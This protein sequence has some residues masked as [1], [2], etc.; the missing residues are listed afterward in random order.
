MKVFNYSELHFSEGTSF[1]IHNL[2]RPVL[3][4]LY[5][6]AEK[7]WKS[8]GHYINHWVP[9]IKNSLDIKDWRIKNYFVYVVDTSDD[10]GKSSDSCEGLC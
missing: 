3:Y 6:Q 9:L 8:S 4:I 2:V 5:P 10:F 7:I 1:K